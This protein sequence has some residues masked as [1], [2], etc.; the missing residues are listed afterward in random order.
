MGRVGE[1]IPAR[2]Q[3][4]ELR[5]ENLKGTRSLKSSWA[6]VRILA[7]PLNVTAAMRGI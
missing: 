7:F 3:S 4:G 2:G 5:S 6:R 1:N